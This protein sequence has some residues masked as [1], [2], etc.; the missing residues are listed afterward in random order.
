MSVETTKAP[1]A[2][3][4]AYRRRIREFL[5]SSSPA[6]VNSASCRSLIHR[7]VKKADSRYEATRMTSSRPY[8]RGGPPGPAWSLAVVASWSVRP[9]APPR[10]VATGLGRAASLEGG[11]ALQAGG[12]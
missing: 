3:P 7:V 10:S 1:A 11:A 9:Q 8:L 4:L 6:M 12:R 2:T 5:I